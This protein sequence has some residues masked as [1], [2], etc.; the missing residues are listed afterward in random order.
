MPTVKH[1]KGFIVLALLVYWLCYADIYWMNPS[2][3][4]VSLLLNGGTLL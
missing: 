4:T 3:K 2:I 1:G